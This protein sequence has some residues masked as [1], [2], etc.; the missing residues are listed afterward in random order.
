MGNQNGLMTKAETM[1]NLIA[2]NEKGVSSTEILNIIYR[3]FKLDLE[4]S[5]LDLPVLPRAAID[6][7][8]EHGGNEVTG[9]EIRKMIN[10]TLAI[11]L[12][13]LSALEG[14][15]ISLYS[16]NQWM[17]QHEKDLFAVHTGTGDIDAR[18]LP[19]NYFIEQTGSGELPIELINDLISLGFYFEENNGSYY[20]SNPTGEP[21][22]DA[23]K[24]QTMMAIRKVNPSVLLSFI[25]ERFI[26]CQKTIEI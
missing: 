9:A 15:K 14:S 12:D 3:V 5:T 11:N 1:D 7:Y 18:I 2:S 24:G 22:P 8:L 6:A 23:F 21:V 17:V 26:I 10:Q 25:R 19:T 20:Y 4:D 16:K 13:A